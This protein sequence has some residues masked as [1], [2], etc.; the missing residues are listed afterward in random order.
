MQCS[1][2]FQTHAMT[3][4]HSRPASLLAHRQ[5]FFKKSDLSIKNLHRL[6][7]D[8][9]FVGEHR[10]TIER[11]MDNYWTVIKNNPEQLNEQDVLYCLHLS[12][13]LHVYYADYDNQLKEQ[14]AALVW[15]ELDNLLQNKK[16]S[17]PVLPTRLEQLTKDTEDF[18][19]MWAH[20]SAIQ[21]WVS[22]LNMQRLSVTFSRLYW[23]EYA[24]PNHPFIPL[25]PFFNA[26]SVGLFAIRISINLAMILKH[27]VLGQEGTWFE[28]L[29]IEAQC[30]HWV[31]VN[32]VLWGLI[33]TLTNY[34]MVSANA[35]GN[36]LGVGLFIDFTWLIWS[37]HLEYGLYQEQKKGL[38]GAFL[39][40]VEAKWQHKQAVLHCYMLAASV[41]FLGY[42]L[43][44]LC[45]AWTIASFLICQVGVSLYCSGE[46]YA[47]WAQSNSEK[48]RDLFVASCTENTIIPLI[49]MGVC[50]LN[51][52]AALLVFVF[53]QGYKYVSQLPEPGED[54]SFIWDALGYKP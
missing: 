17:L 35:A 43:S 31:M 27:T 24:K 8:P 11:A 40:Q 14:H 10:V 46:Q 42:G 39:A 45:P 29:M 32:D 48:D 34:N 2:I 21:S 28:R 38:D 49:I 50:A 4:F 12:G 51:W 9:I 18:F 22:W 23:S 33:N 3:D 47:A 15:C 41:L 5:Q 54:E 26:L 7:I 37:Y 53:Y 13:I 36:L 20:T 16:L 44:M 30:R 52:E 6:E 1:F 25:M 19:F